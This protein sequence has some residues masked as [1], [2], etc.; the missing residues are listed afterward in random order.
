MKDQVDT[1]G[2][3]GELP[4]T[5]SQKTQISEYIKLVES[6]APSSYKKPS[7]SPGLICRYDNPL[8]QELHKQILNLEKS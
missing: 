2:L 4:L 6:G 3:R 1:G 8:N 5:D 7:V